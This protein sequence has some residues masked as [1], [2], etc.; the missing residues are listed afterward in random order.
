MLSAS[1]AIYLAES[2]TPWGESSYFPGIE[3][4]EWK[5]S[6]TIA[7]LG[8]SGL[9]SREDSYFSCPTTFYPILLTCDLLCYFWSSF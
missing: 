7:Y 8:F 2:M 5:V 6:L 1:R 9:L 4:E 3:A